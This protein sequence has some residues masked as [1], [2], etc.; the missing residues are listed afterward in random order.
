MLWTRRLDMHRAAC[1]ARQSLDHE[2][3]CRCQPGPLG[4]HGAVRVHEPPARP[5]GEGG[6]LGEQDKA[7]GAFETLLVVRK[8]STEVTE[9]SRA[10]DRVCHRVCERIGVA[11]ANKRGLARKLDP[12]EDEDAVALI[13]LGARCL[14]P[15][16]IRDFGGEGV[17]VDTKADPELGHRR[18]APPTGFPTR[19]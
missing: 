2:Q 8:V 11:V 15:R 7:V 18:V 16:E 14:L 17:D 3:A 9:A 1:R 13:R 19:R 10:K 6:R 4:H 12:T 5:S